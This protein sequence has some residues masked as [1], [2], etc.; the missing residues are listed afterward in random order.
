[1]DFYSPQIIW[2]FLST[3]SCQTN[4]ITENEML[5]LQ[6][7]P[8]PANTELNIN[9]DELMDYQIINYLG[10][11]IA[12]GR[13]KNDLNIENLERGVYQI[14]LILNKESKSFKFIK[15]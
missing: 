2:D 11:K 1:M 10:L 5:S 14:N 4:T 6:I 8:N 3:K 9:S 13:M 12:S 15:N 7:F